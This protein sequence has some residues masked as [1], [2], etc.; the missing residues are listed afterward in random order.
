ME[1][2]MRNTFMNN[3]IPA[4]LVGIGLYWLLKSSSESVSQTR[5]QEGSLQEE[6]G[7]MGEQV[8]EKFQEA[9]GSVQDHFTQWK[10]RASQQAHEWKS[11]TDQ[12]VE[13]VKEFLKEK[14]S[15]AR[16][17][18]TQRMDAHPL[19]IGTVMVALGLAVAAVIPASRKEHRWRRE[20]RDNMVDAVKTNVQAT[21][22]KVSEKAGEVAEKVFQK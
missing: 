14:G 2:V 11:E 15:V 4:A 17:E 1:Y 13:D 22:E 19:A 3:S 18:F 20:M 10:D 6:Y 5:R 7:A 16:G 9:K 12:K 21:A 8:K